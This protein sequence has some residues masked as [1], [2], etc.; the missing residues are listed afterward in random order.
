MGNLS[1]NTLLNV[2]LDEDWSMVLLQVAEFQSNCIVHPILKGVDK[3][4]EQSCVL[5]VEKHSEQLCFLK[6]WDFS[7]P[8]VGMSLLITLLCGDVA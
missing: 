5:G 3:P 4:I 1:V 6:N 7:S 8:S 2:A